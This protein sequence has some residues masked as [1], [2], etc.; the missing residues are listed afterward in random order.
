MLTLPVALCYE[1]I[2]VRLP[3]DELARMRRVCTAFAHFGRL[4]DRVDELKTDVFGTWFPATTILNRIVHV[5]KDEFDSIPKTACLYAVFMERSV[6]HGTPCCYGIFSC[7]E[8][9]LEAYLQW[10]AGLHFTRRPG[11]TPLHV[12]RYIYKNTFIH[13]YEINDKSNRVVFHGINDE[14]IAHSPGNK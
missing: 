7:K 9:V 5:K 8:R 10:H 4:K 1:I 14:I 12:R 6:N 2:L 11:G 3:L 13:A